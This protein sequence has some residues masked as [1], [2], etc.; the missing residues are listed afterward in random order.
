[1]DAKKHWWSMFEVRFDLTPGMKQAI[2]EQLRDNVD[3]ISNR[4]IKDGPSI[5]KKAFGEIRKMAQESVEKGRDLVG[6][7]K[8]LEDRFGITRRRAAFIARD[9]NNKMTAAFHRS[10]QKDC[11][12]SEAEW[13]ETFASVHPREEHAEFDGQT[14][15]VDEGMWSD[16]AQAYIWPGTEPNCGCLSCSIVP[17]YRSA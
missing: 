13:R 5:P 9:Q 7:T 2:K 15:R 12:I 14:Y 8:D 16:E 17:G 1:M 4:R 6:F 10:R 11:G 3:L